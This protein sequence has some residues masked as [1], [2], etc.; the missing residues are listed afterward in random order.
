MHKV[1]TDII[2]WDAAMHKVITDIWWDAA[3]HKV[4]TDIWWDVASCPGSL[5]LH[6]R[7]GGM[8]SY[9]SG[10]VFES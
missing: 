8:L 10:F 7:L 2:W 6:T 9:H 1:I 4:I 5:R 3:M